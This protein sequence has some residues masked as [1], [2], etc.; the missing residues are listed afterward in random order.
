M[1][2]IQKT[3]KKTARELDEYMRAHFDSGEYEVIFSDDG[4]RDG[5]GEIVKKLEQR[6]ARIDREIGSLKH[7]LD[8]IVRN[9][10]S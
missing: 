2:F 4:S 3:Y 6:S 7:Q 5:C 9:A 10:K 1:N 8:E